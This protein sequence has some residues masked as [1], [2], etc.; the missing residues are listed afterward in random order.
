M[1]YYLAKPE[2]AT[3]QMPRLR[4]VHCS[5][6]STQAGREALSTGEGSPRPRRH[7]AIRSTDRAATESEQ[8]HRHWETQEL[9][10]EAHPQENT[11]TL[12]KRERKK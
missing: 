9:Y 3:Q 4:G 11:C 2:T 7:R 12:G 5:K 6:G 8:N 1:G 10:W